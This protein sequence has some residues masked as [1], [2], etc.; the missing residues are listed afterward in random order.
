MSVIDIH[1]LAEPPLQFVL[2]S[3][4][5]LKPES[6]PALKAMGFRTLY[7]AYFAELTPTSF[8]WELKFAS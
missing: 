2:F 3:S 4:N 5:N 8:Q 1:C 6:L 7:K